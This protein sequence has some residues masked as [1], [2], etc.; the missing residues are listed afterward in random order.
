MPG[1]DPTDDAA[2]Q[3][4]WSSPTE[5]TGGYAGPPAM[6]GH[7]PGQQPVPPVPP[8][9]P[10]TQPWSGQQ[11]QTGPQPSQP[12]GQPPYGQQPGYGQPAHG[13]PDHPTQGFPTGGQPAYGQPAYG[14]PAYGQPAYGQPAYGQPAYGQPGPGQQGYG[15]PPYGQ[16]GYGQQPG[17]QQTQAFAGYSAGY[18]VGTDYL[19]NAAPPPRKRRRALWAVVAAG[20]AAVLVGGGVTAYALLSG[21]G[22]TLD[23][24]VPGDAVVYAEVNVDPPAGQK[25]ATLRFFHHFPDLKTDEDAPD[26]LSGLIE[27]LLTTDKAKREY[28]DDVQPW[29][30]KHAAFVLDPQGGKV[31]PVFVIEAKDE[32]KAKSGL[33]DLQRAEPDNFGYVV[34]DGVAILAE[35]NAIA[36]QAAT[37]ATSSPLHDNSQFTSDIKTVGDDGIFTAWADLGKASKFATDL[38][39]SQ[40]A[41]DIEKADVKGRAVMNV[42]FTDTTADLTVKVL[43]Q[44]PLPKGDEVGAQVAALPADTAIAAGVGGADALVRTSFDRLKKAGLDDAISDIENETGLELPDDVTALV[45]SRTVLAVAGDRDDVRFGVVSHTD[46]PGR[47]K[48]AAEKVLTKLDDTS[49]SIAVKS[50]SDGTVLANSS[51]YAEKLAGNGGL[52]NTDLYRKAVPEAGKA[53]FVAYVDIQK[54]AAF[55]DDPLPDELKSLRA[56][57]VSMVFDGDTATTHARLVVG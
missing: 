57:G 3:S 41:S 11:P 39:G 14:Q 30:G 33:A 4:S 50:I 48:S 22:V 28:R 16:Q 32:A 19:G 2:S 49:D 10:P 36:Q 5:A 25:V 18:P 54:A 20:T 34:Q 24:H 29:V 27:P 44:D 12:Y 40:G 47:A 45:G 1:G 37:G 6:P 17:Y 13:Q 15:Q 52:G 46:D 55:S 35:S 9:Q 53:Q 38:A 43:G 21:T 7:D 31:Q 56:V 26:L 8:A 42:K 23:Q 51:D